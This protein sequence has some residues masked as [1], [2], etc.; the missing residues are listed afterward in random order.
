[1]SRGRVT[2]HQFHVTAASRDAVG[3]EMFALHHLLRASGRETRLYAMKA[4]TLDGV[5]VHGVDQLRPSPRD[6]LVLHYST[7]AP[8]FPSLFDLPCRRAM[9]YHNVTPPD[10]MSGTA[11]L[12]RAAAERGRHELCKYA[13][14]AD[15][16]VAHSA[17]SL[18][19]LHQAG[20]GHATLLPYLQRADLR[21]VR[22]ARAIAAGFED[23]SARLLLVV[24]Q[25]L[26]HKRIE[27]CLLVFDHLRR[28]SPRRWRLV[29]AGNWAGAKTYFLHL[30]AFRRQLALPGVFFTG[31]LPQ[32]ELN[33]CY[34]SASA[35]LTM[36]GH[37]GFCVPIA[38]AMS[39]NVPVFSC[40]GGAPREVFCSA[41]IHF[42]DRDWPRIAEAIDA[43]DH[44]DGFRARLLAAQRD[45]A[46]ELAPDAI[47]PR[48]LQ[49][50]E[51]L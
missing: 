42:E 14:A 20:A 50:I 16:A 9:I 38:E 30:K 39:W 47:A 36:S 46:R 17:F 18:A 19:D 48:W 41:G 25:V 40:A 2:Y 31:P 44:D 45:K 6:W 21:A 29:I 5:A 7:G 33:A 28:C 15:A 43:V 32:A 3:N 35:F 13:P 1:V 10:Q 37:E 24:G 49:W 26:P 27:E 12:L 51:T 34:R 23:P 11:P 22:P 4:G 8:V